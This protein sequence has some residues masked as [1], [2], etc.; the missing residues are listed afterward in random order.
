MKTYQFGNSGPEYVM[1]RATILIPRDLAEWVATQ[2]E[3]TVERG[4]VLMQEHWL[5]HGG[6]IGTTEQA[7]V[8]CEEGL[9]F[10]A[11]DDEES[12][13]DIEDRLGRYTESE[14]HVF[15]RGGLA[16]IFGDRPG[17]QPVHYYSAE[18]RKQRF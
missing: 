5:H 11:V 1:T 8:C 4:A 17:S 15:A 14:C 12:V 2:M 3:V 16:V 18:S 13:Q 9:R 10:E 7:L 6:F